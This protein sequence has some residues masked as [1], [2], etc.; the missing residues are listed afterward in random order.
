MVELK[1]SESMES[2]DSLQSG[3]DGDSYELPDKLLTFGISLSLFIY[4]PSILFI[5]YNS[6]VLYDCI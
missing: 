3:V 1:G 5:D 4:I 2:F 6:I